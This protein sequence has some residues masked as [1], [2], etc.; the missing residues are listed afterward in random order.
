MIIAFLDNEMQSFSVLVVCADKRIQHH[1]NQRLEQK[2]ILQFKLAEERGMK[3][4][5]GV[6]DSE[7]DLL[8]FP[9]C[10]FS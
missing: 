4:V 7:L 10:G 6:T 5:R 8:C 3:E 9:F 2:Y 1:P